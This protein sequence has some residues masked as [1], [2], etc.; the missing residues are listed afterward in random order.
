MTRSVG[1]LDWNGASGCTSSLGYVFMTDLQPDEQDNADINCSHSVR[2][3]Q[4]TKTNEL[5]KCNISFFTC[6]SRLS[7]LSFGLVVDE[8]N[9]VTSDKA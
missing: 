7:S 8:R 4:K 5:L 1:T 6:D 3:S 2:A 9:N